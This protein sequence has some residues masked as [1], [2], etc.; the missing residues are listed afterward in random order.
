MRIRI[1]A[2]MA[3][4]AVA[5]GPGAANPGVQPRVTLV[6]C[7]QEVDRPG[8]PVGTIGIK[9]GSAGSASDQRAAGVG[10]PGERFTLTYARSESA[11]SSPAAA[12][13]VL[14]GNMED[15]RELANQQVRLTGTLDAAAANTAGPQRV[16]VDRVESIAA[17]CTR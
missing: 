13:Y 11:E 14:E 6:G 1:V 17:R 2:G 3:V 8:E 16:R 4:L 9:P 12:S 10:S 5:C 7:L 15:L